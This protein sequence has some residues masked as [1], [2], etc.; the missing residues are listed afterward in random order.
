[1]RASRKSLPPPCRKPA[2][3]GLYGCVRFA[4][5]WR[6]EGLAMAQAQRRLHPGAALHALRLRELRRRAAARRRRGR[7]L[8]AD[9]LRLAGAVAD[10]GPDR[11][12]LRRRR[13]SRTSGSAIRRASTT[14]SSSAGWS[15]RSR[16][17]I[18]TP[19]ASSRR[20]AAA[21]VPLVGVCT[22][23]FI[24]H[25]AGLMQGYRACVSWFHH[26]D[27]LERFDGLEPVSRPDLRRRPRPADLLGRGLLGAS[28]RLHRRAASRAGAGGE[29]P[30]HHDHRRGDGGGGAAA[31]A[32]RWRSPPTTRW[33]AR[34]SSSCSSR[35]TRRCRSA[36]WS[37]GS[38]SA[39]ASSSGISARRSA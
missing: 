19:C 35:S 39:G 29:E 9:P 4:V 15:T 2:A 16:T 21:G 34:R 33:C 37:R 8:A 3:S 11:V 22:G 7:P 32:C 30:A 6:Q 13:C 38:G 12:E 23:T 28:R 36:G 31:R 10:D 24:L 5:C 14:S 27:F 25:R 20:A 1:M 18:P 26:D 17:C